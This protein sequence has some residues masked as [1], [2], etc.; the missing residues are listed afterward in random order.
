ML[1]DTDQC[2]DRR[3]LAPVA[4]MKSTACLALAA[5][6][7]AG[8]QANDNGLGLTPPQGWRS[9]NLYGNNVNQ[10]LIT[11]IMDGMVKKH[12]YGGSKE[13]SLC[14]GFGYCDVGLDDHWQMC[15]SPDAAP[16]MNYHA[17]NGT[18]LINYERFPSLGDM[19]KHAHAL[20][21]TSGFCESRIETRRPFSV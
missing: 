16:G 21:L 2:S 18:P 13:T 10:S 14:E 17:K 8:V 5:L 15:G 20:N 12:S 9:W 3:T 6:F 19:V 1:S 11:G 4:N 7:T